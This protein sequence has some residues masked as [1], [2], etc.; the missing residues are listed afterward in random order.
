MIG[1]MTISWISKKQGTMT[2]SFYET[3]YVAISNATRQ[4]LWI[5]MLVEELD[6]NEGVN[7]KLLVEN[8]LNQKLV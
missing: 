7:I 8:K 2:R 6:F 1:A 4:A 5:E 3:R